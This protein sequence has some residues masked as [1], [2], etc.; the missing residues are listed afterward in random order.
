MGNSDSKPTSA[1]IESGKQ[2]ELSES[3]ANETSPLASKDSTDQEPTRTWGTKDYAV[4]LQQA[5]TDPIILVCISLVTYLGL[6]WVPHQITLMDRANEFRLAGDMCH[7]CSFLVFMLKLAKSQSAAG[8]SALTPE[9][10]LVVFLARY[11]DLWTHYISTYNTTMKILYISLTAFIL[12]TIRIRFKSSYRAEHDNFNRL[13]AYIPCLLVALVANDRFTGQ[14]VLWAF[15]IYLEALA[16]IPQLIALRKYGEL[17]KYM[18]TYLIL[19]GCYRALYIVNWIYRDYTE[20][21]YKIHMNVF[22]AGVFQT[23]PYVYFFATM[24]LKS[25]K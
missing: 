18:L 6:F 12:L 25:Y 23:I 11:T 5:L 24:P 21:L 2:V 13:W 8:V 3:D 17:D 9:I 22:V 10:S 4:R 16:I 19:R 14:E 7:L 20:P 15:S 1:D